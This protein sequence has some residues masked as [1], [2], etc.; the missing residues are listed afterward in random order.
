M[1]VL[2]NGIVIYCYPPNS[3]PSP[4]YWTSLKVP[5][6]LTSTT[7]PPINTELQP[8]TLYVVLWINLSAVCFL[9]SKISIT[10]PFCFAS[11]IFALNNTLT[12]QYIPFSDGFTTYT[13]L[14]DRMRVLCSSLSPNMR[15]WA[16]KCE[17]VVG[18]PLSK[19]CWVSCWRAHK[20]G[21]NISM[22]SWQFDR[23]AQ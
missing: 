9:L 19:C 14:Q 6:C 11:H 15:H 22:R 18:I 10:D 5:T 2:I 20:L 1:F 13:P 17:Q 21:T 3:L 16:I 8:D 23:W 12:I 4:L 7:H